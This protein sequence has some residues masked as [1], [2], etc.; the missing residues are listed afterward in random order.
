MTSILGI[1]IKQAVPV[2]QFLQ[3]LAWRFSY[4]I[5]CT[6]Q[7]LEFRAD[8]TTAGLKSLTVVSQFVYLH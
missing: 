7:V 5:A 1:N 2:L 8:I 3:C 4:F 6:T